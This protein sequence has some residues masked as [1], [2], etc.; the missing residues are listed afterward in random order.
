MIY[1]FNFLHSKKNFRSKSDR[2]DCGPIK[3]QVALDFVF[4]C[5]GG[6]PAIASYAVVSVFEN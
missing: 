6:R 1:V 3:R 2:H 4:D 5:T